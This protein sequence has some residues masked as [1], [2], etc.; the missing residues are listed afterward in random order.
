MASENFAKSLE[1]TLHHEGGYVNHPSDPGGITNLGITKR[2]YEEWVGHEVTADD[3][4]A[5]TKNDVAPIYKKKY[6]DRLKGDQLPGGLDY[7][8]FDFGVNGGTSRAAKYL[9]QM[10]G[11]TA[12]GAIGPGT[13]KKVEE[14]IA[15]HGIEDAIK[16][17]QNDRQEYYQR[18]KHFST[19]GKGWTNRVADTT[20]QALRMS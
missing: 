11:A 6:W 13:L 7:V 12:D 5:L 19:F 1:Q 16:Q 20:S 9:Q 17:Y 14:Y 10:I 2:V 8:V 15:K 4:K 3:M 18:L